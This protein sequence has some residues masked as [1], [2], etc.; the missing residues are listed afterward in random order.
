MLIFYIQPDDMV[1]SFTRYL[2]QVAKELKDIEDGFLPKEHHSEALKGLSKRCNMC[3][4]EFMR[5]LEV[6]D[7]LQFGEHQNIAKSKR[8]SVVNFTN[9]NL[10]NADDLL[11]KIE[12][13]TKK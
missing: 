3:L 13:L 7:G 12:S 4:E 8:K 9:S 6:L 10:D 2:F 1:K 5:S 11:Q